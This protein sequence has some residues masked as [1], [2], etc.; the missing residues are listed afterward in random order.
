M[1]FLCDCEALDS[2]ADS[3]VRGRGVERGRAE[4]IW[5]TLEDRCRLPWMGGARRVAP[6]VAAAPAAVA[7]MLWASSFGKERRL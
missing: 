5:R 2:A 1:A 3:L 7:A 4:E 6:E